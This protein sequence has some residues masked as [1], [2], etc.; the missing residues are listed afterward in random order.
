MKLLYDRTEGARIS[1]ALSIKDMRLLVLENDAL[2]ITMV[3][4]KG[5]DILEF[6]DKRTQTDFLWRSP[7]GFRSPRVD[8][9][10]RPVAGTF[11]AYYAGGWQELF[12]HGSSPLEVAGAPMGQH[13]E[14]HILPW[15][16]AILADTPQEVRVKL[17][18]NT[19][20]TPFR[21]EKTIILNA[22]DPWVRFEEA[23]TN[24]SDEP[25]DIIW[26][27]HPAFGEPFLSGDCK[28]ELPPG[29]P[30]DGEL[31]FC[32]IQ[33]KSKRAPN[34][35]WYLT[36]ITEGWY[37]IHNAKRDVGF[38]MAW[39]AKRFGVIWIWQ[40]YGSEGGHPNYGREYVCAVEPVSSLPGRYREAIAPRVPI[41]PRETLSTSFHAFSYGGTLAQTL[42]RIPG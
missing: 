5:T 30:I 9:R 17:W 38:G 35:M 31:S 33:P 27:H 18:V 22:S 34:R 6:L 26:G 36:D 15:Q 8:P 40:S 11:G 39:D 12:P 19:V 13:G 28:I 25:L 4:E 37:G 3:P 42:E 24:L 2:R 23:A 32:R 1:D 21:L 16:Y 29:E 14:V 20:L 7:N 10:L 41:G